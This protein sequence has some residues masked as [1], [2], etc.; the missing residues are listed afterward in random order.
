VKASNQMHEATLSRILNSTELSQSGIFRTPKRKKS[1]N[2]YS[3]YRPDPQLPTLDSALWQSGNIN[4][5]SKPSIASDD[6]DQM[7]TTCDDV[8]TENDDMRTPQNNSEDSAVEHSI[9]IGSSIKSTWIPPNTQY[10]PDV[11]DDTPLVKIKCTG[12]ELCE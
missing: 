7:L 6:K 12:A 10:I 1:S 8:K 2:L 9:E 3:T 5:I 11:D 4:H